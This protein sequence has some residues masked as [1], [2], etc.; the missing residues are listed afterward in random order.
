MEYRWPLYDRDLVQQ[1]FATPAIEKRRRDL[2]RYLHRRA[3]QGRIPEQILWQKGKDLGN[4]TG[5]RLNIEVAEPIAF[6]ALPS[7]L[8]TL[9]D[10]QAYERRSQFLKSSDLVANEDT[11][12]AHVF[13]WQLR[14]LAAWLN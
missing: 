1:Y 6:D 11:I 3:M 14:Q 7:L 5:E 13:F 8:R 2:G 12:N 10:R 4:H 9:I